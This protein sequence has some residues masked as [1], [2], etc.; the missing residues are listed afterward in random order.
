MNNLIYNFMKLIMT[1]HDTSYF[2][3]R[4]YYDEKFRREYEAL[5]QEEE[6]KKISDILG[7]AKNLRWIGFYKDGIEIN[8]DKYRR[9]P[10]DADCENPQVDIYGQY[11]IVDSFCMFKN[12]NDD[13]GIMVFLDKS[14]TL[15]SGDVLSLRNCNL[16]YFI[17]E[18]ER[19]QV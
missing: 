7:S 5:H 16:K 4:E 12:I 3:I 13:I 11:G 6:R 8:V 14:R 2:L 15:Q 1:P 9:Y 17:D 10:V 18:N 19:E